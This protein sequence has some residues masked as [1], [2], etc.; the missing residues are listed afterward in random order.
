MRLFIKNMVCPRCITAVTEILE[1]SGVVVKSVTLGE[2]EIAEELTDKEKTRLKAQLE[3]SGF[4]LLEDRKSRMVEAVKN[5]IIELVRAQTA[6]PDVNLSDYLADKLRVD[7]KSL[8]S[9]FSATQGRTIENYYIAQKI[10]RVKELLVYDELTLSEIAF[11]LGY[12]SVAHLSAQFK[13]TT[14]LTP[15]YYK[16]RSE[17]RRQPLDDL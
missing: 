2:A 3:A 5:S 12:S 10:E 9:L 1:R 13:H 14:G 17:H 4:E 6:V 16:R 7:Y 8:S 15:S 11:R